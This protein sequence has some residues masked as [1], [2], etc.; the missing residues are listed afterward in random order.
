MNS[1]F[2]NSHESSQGI[3]GSI[4][5]DHRPITSHELT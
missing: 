5:A 2:G 3:V 1:R 4:G